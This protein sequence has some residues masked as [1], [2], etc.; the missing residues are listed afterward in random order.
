MM[1]H[2]ANNLELIPHELIPN[3]ESF[4]QNLLSLT[5]VFIYHKQGL[6]STAAHLTPSREPKHKL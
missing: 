2:S 4:G 6:N 1:F 5:L 3:E